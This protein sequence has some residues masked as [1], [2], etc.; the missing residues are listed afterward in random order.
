VSDEDWLA[1]AAER[2]AVEFDASSKKQLVT[3][4]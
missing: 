1:E 3:A 2:G 4:A